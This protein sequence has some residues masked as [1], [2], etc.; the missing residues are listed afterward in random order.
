MNNYESFSHKFT[1]FTKEKYN[2]DIKIK[3]KSK[4]PLMIMMMFF[5]FW[6]NPKFMSYITVIGKTIYVP[7]TFFQNSIHIQ[8][9][10]LFHELIHVKQS[11]KHKAGLFFALY[12]FPQIIILPF[13][14]T[15]VPLVVF[16]SMHW[17]WLF[18]GILFLLPWPAYWRFKFEKEAY[19]DSDL[20]CD[21]FIL[22]KD[23]PEPSFLKTFYGIDYYLM[24]PFK[25]NLKKLVSKK[26]KQ[27]ENKIL[28]TEQKDF[29]LW[30]KEDIGLIF[31]RQVD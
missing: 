19:F 9:R 26:M 20:F 13:L 25:N 27:Y 2:I 21:Y 6:F 5:V 1:K 31:G 11:I 29:A 3:P 16:T 12:L 22:R 28:T 7:S 14:M 15:V 30:L 10:V 24:W 18:L 23:A 8:A 4:S 17:S